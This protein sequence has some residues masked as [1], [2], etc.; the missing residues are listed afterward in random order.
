MA[1]YRRSGRSTTRKVV[2]WAA[3]ILLAGG[4]TLFIVW[5]PQKQVAGEISFLDGD[6]F[7]LSGTEIRLYGIDAPEGRQ[8]CH[9]A[10]GSEYPCGREASRALRRLAQGKNVTCTIVTKDRYARNVAKC[11]TDSLELNHEM[12]RLGWAIAYR[13]RSHDYTRADS[14]AKNAKRGIWQGD[15][16]RPQDWRHE[17]AAA[18]HASGKKPP[19][20]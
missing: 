2:D 10:N 1:R 11:N 5:L 12:V 16:K 14:E 3:F 9:R 4:V 13:A 19:P 8:T 6:S 7:I 18:A 17:R 20:D 15:F